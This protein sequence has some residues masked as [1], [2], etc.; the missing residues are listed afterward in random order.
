MARTGA[1]AQLSRFGGSPSLLDL[2]LNQNQADIAAQSSASQLLSDLQRKAL[3]DAYN[4]QLLAMNLRNSMFGASLSSSRDL[5]EKNFALQK[6]RLREGQLSTPEWLGLLALTNLMNLGTIYLSRRQASQQRKGLSD[7]LLN[8]QNYL[9]R[10][11]INYT[12]PN[13]S[14]LLKSYRNFRVPILNHPSL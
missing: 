1:R 13:L 7:M 2:L 5:A 12:N 11:I 6:R 14:G 4:R 8:Y 9:N 10:D 3:E